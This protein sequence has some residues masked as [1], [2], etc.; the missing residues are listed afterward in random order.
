MNACKRAQPRAFKVK[1]DEGANVWLARGNHIGTDVE[2]AA[3]REFASVD[4]TGEVEGGKHQGI[5]LSM[6]MRSS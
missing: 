2:D 6:L 3:R 4:A 5:R 1:A